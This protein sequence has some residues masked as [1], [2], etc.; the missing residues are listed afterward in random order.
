MVERFKSIVV[1]RGMMGAAAARYL[2]LQGEGVAVI[3]PDEPTD[4]SNHHGVFASHY[5]EARITRTIDSDPIWARLANRSIARYGEIAAESG[6]DFYSEVGCLIVGPKRGGQDPYVGLVEAAA[7]QLGVSVEMLSDAAL[8]SRF[9]YFDFGSDCEGVYEEKNAGYVNPRRLVEAQSLLA[10]KAGAR[11]IRRTAVSVREEGGLAIVTTDD[12]AVY[13]AER[14][15]VAAG[16][17]SINENLVPRPLD[18]KVYGRTVAFF[19]IPEEDLAAYTGMPSLI[20]QPDDPTDHI[21]LLPPVRYPDGKTYLK[22]GGD[23]DDLQLETEPE[24]RAWFRRG[25]RLTTRDHLRRIIS[26]L[27]PT[28]ADAPISMA[29][30]VTSFTPENY[31][32]IGFASDHIAVLTG[33]CGAAAKSSD[34]IG[35]LGAEFIQH[36]RIIDEAYG[37]VFRPVF[38]D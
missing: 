37:D 23:P 28:L 31:P 21:Y 5:D 12:G 4:W 1:G 16:G 14:V 29:A 9:R 8:K 26:D 33:G 24:I 13:T 38:R 10:G 25:G 22:I 19:E 2:A 11:V 20:H 32:A 6:I 30:C 36:G 17:F 3:G 18:L 15:L 35:R 7:H 34:E 27:V